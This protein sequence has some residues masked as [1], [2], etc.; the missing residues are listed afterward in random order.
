MNRFE[1]SLDRIKK[2]VFPNDD[3]T[4]DDVTHIKAVT[5]ALEKQIPTKPKITIKGTTGY[6]TNTLC[7]ICGAMVRS[8]DN[9]C[10]KCGQALDWKWRKT[11]RPTV[12]IKRC[13]CGGTPEVVKLYP[14]KRYDCFIRCTKCEREGK[15]YVSKQGA[16]NAWNRE[17]EK[18]NNE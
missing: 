10:N 7:P 14:S 3:W 2:Y 17:V 18:E 12:E 8:C 11:K 9:H 4:V 5:D 15:V 16:V 1:Q 13:S 6:N